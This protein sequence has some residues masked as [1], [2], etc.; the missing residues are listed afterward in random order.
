MMRYDRGMRP[1]TAVTLWQSLVRPILEYASEIWSG[2]IPKYIEQKAEAVQLKFLRV[3]LGLHK[4]GSGVCNEVV[5]AEAG[6]ERL[7]DRWTKLRMGYWRRV[8]AA[9]H[10]RLL[11][12]LIDFRR[13]EWDASGGRGWGAKGWVGTVKTTLDLHGLGE[14]WGSP[15][16]AAA[17][18]APEWKTRVYDAVDARSD[19]HRVVSL[20]TK[21]SATTYTTIKAWGPNPENY[22]AFTGEV[23]KLG[24]HVPERYLDDRINLKGTRLKMLCRLGCLP[25]MERVGREAK[26]PWPRDLRTCAACNTGRVEDV[27]HF[28]MDCPKYA[29]KRAVLLKQVVVELAKSEGDL[30]AVQFASMEPV[31]QL[32]VL[33]GKRFSDPSTEDRLDRTVKRFLSKCWN[34]RSEVTGA[35]ND[36]LFTSYGIYTAPVA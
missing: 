29:V 36:A 4:S 28:M 13:R 24:Q 18:D 1:R 7:R 5:R 17:M 35:V 20:T 11:R 22:S 16:K 33:L 31:D 32:P 21:P 19:A 9:P 34:L 12:D 15:E 3:T 8:F 27:H 30:K 26:P 23:G 2:Q 14:F 10:G 25:L 6:C